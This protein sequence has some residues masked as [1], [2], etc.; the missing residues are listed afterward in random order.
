MCAVWWLQ[1]V[2][3]AHKRY[4]SNPYSLIVFRDS[5]LQFSAL[6]KTT[7]SLPLTCPLPLQVEA[8]NAKIMG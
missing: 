6:T 8:Q 2:P 5:I 3:G 1:V 7:A 4:L